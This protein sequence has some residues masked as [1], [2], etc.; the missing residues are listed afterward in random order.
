MTSS[1]SSAVA[2][3]L[4]ALLAEI[5]DLINEVQATGGSDGDASAL[6]NTLSTLVQVR[7]CFIFIFLHFYSL[8]YSLGC[9][10]NCGQHW[11]WINEHH[12]RHWVCY[13]RLLARSSLSIAHQLSSRDALN[14][15]INLV[16]SLVGGVEDILSN[17]LGALG[18]G[19]IVVGLLGGLWL[20]GVFFSCMNSWNF[21]D[22]LDY[23][24]DEFYDN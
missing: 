5:N 20:V 19:N 14:S 22:E 12:S 4:D 23:D 13:F 16:D 7:D 8:R 24:F 2:S 17:L 11:Q 6:A 15:L 10:G 21:C 3:D 9:R 18:L 1:N